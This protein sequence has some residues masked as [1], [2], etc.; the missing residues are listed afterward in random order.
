MAM[1]LP[2]WKAILC[3]R[4]GDDYGSSDIVEIKCLASL[5]TDNVIWAYE[6]SIWGISWGPQVS[7]LCSVL[8]YAQL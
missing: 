3:L 2:I 5:A 4:N 8:N 6:N 1:C 7:N